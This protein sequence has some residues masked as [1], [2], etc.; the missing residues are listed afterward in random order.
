MI[1]LLIAEEPTSARVLSACATR[2]HGDGDAQERL[3]IMRYGC[4]KLCSGVTRVEPA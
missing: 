4:C 2:L 3:Q 1:Q